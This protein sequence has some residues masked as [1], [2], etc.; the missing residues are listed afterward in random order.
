MSFL[1]KK[2]PVCPVLPDQ[3]QV[4]RREVAEL[5]AERDALT[6]QLKGDIPAA[7]AWLQV[8]VWRQRLALDGLN[9]TVIRQRFVLRTLQSLGRGLTKEEYLVA[10]DATADG[11]LRDRI[12]EDAAAMG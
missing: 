10:R 12:S 1:K 6:A 11:Q 8:K 9:R 5:R 3:V 7:T 4:L 2:E